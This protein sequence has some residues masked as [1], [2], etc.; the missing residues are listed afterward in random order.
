M[1][2]RICLYVTALTLFGTA[3]AQ[4]HAAL[5]PEKVHVAGNRKAEAYLTDGVV[6]GGDRAIDEVTVKDI[7][8]AENPG[9]E[10]LVIDLEGTR[11]G[12]PAS[13]PRPSY[14]QVATNLE[15]KRLIVSLWGSPKLGFDSRKVLRAF[16]KS[17]VISSVDLLPKIEDEQWTF[18]LGLK[19]AKSVEVFELTDPVR[20]IVDIRSDAKPAAKAA[21][22]KAK[23]AAPQGHVPP[24][25]SDPF[26][27]AEIHGAT[28]H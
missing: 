16:K 23:A 18:S 10:R 7:R 21:K 6:V 14:F 27:E 20:I 5:H 15:E 3:H 8:R 19:S 28:E 1:R 26:E 24:A 2:H 13:I 17:A 25:E 11:H 9:Y 12:E 4:A 22:A